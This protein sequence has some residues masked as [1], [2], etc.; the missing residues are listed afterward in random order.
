MP[1]SPGSSC[2][3]DTPELIVDPDSDY[4]IVPSVI[5]TQL[6]SVP[7]SKPFETEIALPAGAANLAPDDVLLDNQ[8]SVSV[9]KN[10]DLLSNIRPADIPCRISGVNKN[11]KALLC[12]RVGDFEGIK[13]IYACPDAS[14]NIVSFSETDAYCNNGYRKQL[15]EFYSIPPGGPEK[16]F[17]LRDGLYVYSHRRSEH[18]VYGPTVSENLQE[19]S[20][21]EQADAAKARDLFH[22]LAYPGAQSVTDMLNLGS[23][24][25]CPV[26][27]KDV[28]RAHQI[29]GKHQIAD[30]RGK[31]HRRTPEIVKVESIPRVISSEVVL[32]VD[33]MFV[34]SDAFLISVGTP[35]GITQVHE[36]GRSKRARALESVRLKLNK[37]IAEFKSRKFQVIALNTDGEGAIYAMTKELQDQGI[38][39]NPAGPGMHVPVIEIKIK[40]VKERSRGIFHSLPFSLAASLI[41]WLV[42]FCVSRIN[43]VPHKSGFANISPTE[44]FLGRKTDYKRDLRCG[45]ADYAECFDPYS[46][47]TIRSRTHPAI[48]LIPTGNRSG[49]VKFLSLVSGK[50]I[51]RDQFVILPMPDNVIAH[52]NALAKL[53]REAPIVALDFSLSGSGNILDTPEDLFVYSDDPVVLLDEDRVISA[54]E[55]QVDPDVVVVEHAA[56]I[57]SDQLPGPVSSFSPVTQSPTTDSEDESPDREPEIVPAPASVEESIG[58]VPIPTPEASPELVPELSPTVHQYSTRSQSR[59]GGR[60]QWDRKTNLPVP[61]NAER[62]EQAYFAAK[63]R[64]RDHVFNISVKKAMANM[65]TEAITSMYKQIKQ[66][67]DKSVWVG[68]APSFKHQKR[69]IRS[70]MFLKEKFLPNGD[71]DKLKARLVAGGHMQ[72]RDSVDFEDTS[73]PT[74]SLPFLF[75]IASIAAREGRHVRTFD[76][77]GAYLNADISKQEILMEL[78]Q[79]ASAILMQIDPSFE[80]YVRPNGTIVVELKKALYG[81]I[82]SA[83]L[84]Y[85]LLSATLRSKGYVQNPIDPCVFNKTVGNSQCTVVIYVD[86]LLV[87]CADL[88]L[89]D[90]LETVLK[91][92]FKEIT[93]HDGL[94]HSYLGM[95]FDFADPGSVKVRMAG[96]TADTLKFSNTDGT[97]KTPAANHLFEVRQSVLLDDPKREALHSITAKLLY[98]AKRTRP[99]ILLPVSFLTTRVQA[100]DEDDWNKLQRVLRYLNGTQDLGICLRADCPT[101]VTAHID[102]SYGVHIDGKSHSGMFVSLGSGPILVKSSKQKIVTKSSTEAELVALSDLASLVIWSR[103]FLLAQGEPAG[104]AT[105]SQ[106]NQSTMALAARGASVSERTRHINIRHYWMKDRVDSGDIQ[107]MYTPTEDMIADIFTKPLQGERFFRLRDLLLNWSYA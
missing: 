35:L 101:N 56:D 19:F 78:D 58:S 49:S 88:S 17:P 42:Y 45:F 29:W 80:Q 103:D 32:N 13:D 11:S 65:S 102:A 43:L 37:Q 39:V 1:V 8:A 7:E 86:D 16:R 31:T 40:E 23:I 93:K 97:A 105:V 62:R 71:F 96:Y 53:N 106:D 25:N 66:M 99:D 94:V 57:T 90:E 85:D 46:D 12:D 10:L 21:R 30:L 76:I 75:M 5:K 61:I 87:T 48:S 63:L 92:E 59:G 50:V 44:A 34:D 104:P 6:P 68:K 100:P 84:W 55:A 69:V 98:L 14:A 28:A 33:I 4:D 74:A 79:T 3:D 24:I 36:L 95:E 38:E 82:E 67:V 18:P 9:F 73:S 2:P 41:V 64:S 89:I 47:N 15:K 70:F 27:S 54:E 77:G 26:T 72:D 81:C 51:T 83:K 52:L 60:V 91:T 22:R 20:V 107:I